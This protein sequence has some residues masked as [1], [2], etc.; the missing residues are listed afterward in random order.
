MLEEYVFGKV[1]PNAVALEEV[2][3]GALMLDKNAHKQV[4]FLT[5][6][7]F[8]DDRHAEIFKAI[9]SLQSKLAPVD[10]LTVSDEIKKSNVADQVSPQY[11]AQLTLRIAS[12]ANLEY[13][14]RIVKQ[15][16]VQ[17][18]II[19]I[20]NGMIGKAY[21]DDA[22]PFE[23]LDES[24][25]Q[26][27]DVRG[28]QER[29][30]MTGAELASEILLQAQRVFERGG[31][32]GYPITG[33]PYLDEMFGGAEEADVILIGAR[34][35]MGKSSLLNTMLF[36]HVTT[37]E[38]AYAASAEMVNTMTG[39]RLASAI[40]GI[41]TNELRE[42]KFI[43]NQGMQEKFNY[44]YEKIRDSKIL[45]DD[46]GFSMARINDI[47]IRGVDKG[48]K[49]FYFDRV[50]LVQEFAG[51]DGS[52]W[53][54]ALQQIM[55]KMRML[56][57]KHKVTIVPFIQGNADVEKTKDKRMEARHVFGGTAGQ[58]AA[59]KVL[60]IYRP[61]GYGMEN[62][63]GGEFIGQSAKGRAEISLLLATSYLP[64]SVLVG[65][66][67]PGQLFYSLSAQTAVDPNE[68]IPF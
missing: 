24:T 32:L 53:T 22:D 50:E 61:E 5:P 38:P 39:Y 1:A 63:E 62:F 60:T 41:S 59:T 40:S 9:R 11:L 30:A 28:S 6:K 15:K 23:L 19:S 13:H 14:A 36:N 68:S 12:T 52:S 66:N 43:V 56:A 35:K 55:T 29:E 25:R 64:K 51:A 16:S 44:A 48:I 67:G 3:L 58:A 4:E 46:S 21:H 65:F 10:I 42:G 18:E 7:D 20:A 31:R 49:I 47:I 57:T 37:G 26:L 33:I 2:V 17:R 8:Y 45:F 27:L 54:H 34:P